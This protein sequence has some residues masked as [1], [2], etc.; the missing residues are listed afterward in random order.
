[1]S[2]QG[3]QQATSGAA[4]K[5]STPEL[6][7]LVRRLHTGNNLAM[8][9]LWAVAIIVVLSFLGIIVF[10]LVQGVQYLVDPAFYAPT[11]LGVGSQIFNT[12]YVLILAEVILFPI[13]LSAAI[14]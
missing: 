12:F 14:Y 2:T 3:V 9:I 1:M 4:A 10:L 8:S 11:D 6:T 5:T 7:R 13:A